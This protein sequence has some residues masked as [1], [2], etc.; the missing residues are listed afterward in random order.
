[1]Q[2]TDFWT[3]IDL[4]LSYMTLA[5]N[6]LDQAIIIDDPPISLF[7]MMI[8]FVVLEL[9]LTFINAFRGRGYTSSGTGTGVDKSSASGQ[10]LSEVMKKRG[11]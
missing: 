4:L 9:V 10:R 1:M 7:D 2:L 6:S 5:F 11:G 3:I 8:G